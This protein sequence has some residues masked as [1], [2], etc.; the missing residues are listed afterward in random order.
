[1]KPSDKPLIW[2]RG[3]VKTPPLSAVARLEAG[4]LL[5]ALQAGQLLGLP[6][7]RPMPALGPHCH[8]LRVNDVASTW[9]IVYRIDSDAILIL[10]V[11]QKQT[12][13]TPDHVIKACRRSLKKYDADTKDA[14]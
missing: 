9:R 10:G 13:K 14:D 7:S 5:R 3:E 2:L 11:F 12:G 8:E 4:F 1:M 6:R